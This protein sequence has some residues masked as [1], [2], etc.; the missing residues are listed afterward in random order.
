MSKETKPKNIRATEEV[1]DRF[2][3]LAEE[4]FPNQGSALEAFMNAWE[5]QNAKNAV[6]E[7]EA[8][9]SDFDSHVQALQRA[10]IHSLDV[11]QNASARARDEFRRKLEAL[12]TEKEELRNRL[13]LANSNT[14]YYKAQVE[15][16]EKAAKEAKAQAEAATKHA[17]ALEATVSDKQ[18]I[19]DQL[20]GRTERAEEIAEKAKAQAEKLETENRDSRQAIRNLENDLQAAQTAAKV[21][22]ATAVAT[23]AEAVSKAKEEAAAK[24]LSLVEENGSLKAELEKVKATLA[25]QAE[26]VSPVNPA[27]IG[28]QKP[29]PAQ[30]KLYKVTYVTK[31]GGEQR[32]EEFIKAATADE[33]K[34]KLK[35]AREQSGEEKKAHA[36]QIEAKP[37][38]AFMEPIV[39]EPTPEPEHEKETQT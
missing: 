24:I 13:N 21:A 33:A 10:Y 18:K 19:I 35:A 29:N 36:F 1:H 3:Q 14:E 4:N 17:T 5:I 8:D 28:D 26:A 11:A 7:R 38:D 30:E 34:A 25:A 16:A 31:K 9:I 39:E 23:Q 20:T 22:A 6:P 12:E 27:P 2:A 15:A 32:H 37:H